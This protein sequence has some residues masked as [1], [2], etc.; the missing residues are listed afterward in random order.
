[1]VQEG[2]AVGVIAAQSIGEPGTQLTL[3]T[4]HTG[5]TAGGGVSE[6]EIRSKNP[7]TLEVEELRTVEKM[8]DTG[9]M[10]IIVV[11]RSS[12]LKIVDENTGIALMTANIPYGSTLHARPGATV[13]KGDLICDWDPYNSCD[14]FGRRRNVQVRR[15]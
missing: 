10:K 9:E 11:S 7:G 5:G 6:A 12:E 8:S 1:M 2:Q 14:H 3:R 15:S 13:K 4:F